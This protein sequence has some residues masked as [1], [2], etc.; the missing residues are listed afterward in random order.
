[1]R[2]FCSCDLLF[3][4]AAMSVVTHGKWLLRCVKNFPTKQNNGR[5][6][7]SL[8]S[9]LIHSIGQSFDVK[10]SISGGGGTPNCA[11]TWCSRFHITIS[12]IV[13]VTITYARTVIH[14]YTIHDCSDT[15]FSSMVLYAWINTQWTS[16]FCLRRQF[17]IRI[18]FFLDLLSCVFFCVFCLGFFFLVCLRNK[19][20]SL[21]FD[22]FLSRF[23]LFIDFN[24][25]RLQLF[26]PVICSAICSWILQRYFPSCSI[27]INSHCAKNC[28]LQ[29]EKRNNRLMSLLKHQIPFICSYLA[30][31]DW[32]MI[33]LRKPKK[34]AIKK[35]LFRQICLNGIGHGLD[36]T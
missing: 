28:R 26:Q 7:W 34:S 30:C 32:H 2:I 5:Q 24:I 12:A 16:Y 19:F 15:S 4:L 1:M 29:R 35:R 10:P 33:L 18:F 20:V 27:Q 6:E 14:L 31:S 22:V 36:T 13:D 25:C 21:L 9:L 3:F 17:F 23:H 8:L 11:C